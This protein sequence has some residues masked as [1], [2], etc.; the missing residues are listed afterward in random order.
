MEEVQGDKRCFGKQNSPSRKEVF[1]QLSFDIM[2]ILLWVNIYHIKAEV[3]HE[4][5]V[6][7]FHVKNK[8]K[9]DKIIPFMLFRGTAATVRHAKISLNNGAVHNRTSAPY[10]TVF[11]HLDKEIGEK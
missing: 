4:K 11:R 8:Q 2:H 10:I 7:L 3:F 6:Y 1:R 5:F 9:K